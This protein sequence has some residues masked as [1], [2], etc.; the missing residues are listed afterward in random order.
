MS[1]ETKNKTAA[2]TVAENI[3]TVAEAVESNA[4]TAEEIAHAAVTVATAPVQKPTKGKKQ[5]PP[6]NA[7][8]TASAISKMGEAVE[9]AA[10]AAQ[11]TNTS[12]LQVLGKAACK[13]HGLPAVWVTA[14]GQCFPQENDARNHGKSLGLSAEPIKVEA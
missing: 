6:K 14:D 2:E 9:R 1:N 7:E 3:T 4:A 12:A 11:A 5:Q 13:R 8:K 10:N